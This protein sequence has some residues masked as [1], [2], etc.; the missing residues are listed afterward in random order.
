MIDRFQLVVAG[1]EIVNAFSELNDPLEQIRR[2]QEQEKN[3]ADG[4]AEADEALVCVAPTAEAPDTCDAL[5]WTFAGPDATTIGGST[6]G[7]TA[8]AV[9]LATVPD[10]GIGAAA[11]TTSAEDDAS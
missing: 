10:A 3:K 11:T 2:F 7:T 8:L 5:D 1:F 9:E 4:D 6:P